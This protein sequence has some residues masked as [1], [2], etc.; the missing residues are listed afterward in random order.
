MSVNLQHIKDL[1]KS[2]FDFTTDG[3]FTDALNS[4]V[5][6]LHSFSVLVVNNREEE[7][8]ALNLVP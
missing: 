7:Q 5:S 8:E 6:C 2:G 1:H 4:F 3:K